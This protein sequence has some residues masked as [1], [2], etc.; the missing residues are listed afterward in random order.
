[1][2]LAFLIGACQIAAGL[3]RFGQNCFTEVMRMV[4]LDW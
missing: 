3:M 2:L 1:M 4:R